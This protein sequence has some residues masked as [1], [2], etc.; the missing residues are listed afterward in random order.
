MRMWCKFIFLFCGSTYL[1]CM[2]HAAILG[3]EPTAPAPGSVR[4]IFVDRMYYPVDKKSDHKKGAAAIL[5][6]YNFGY[7]NLAHIIRHIGIHVL[8][9]CLLKWGSSSVWFGGCFF[10][11]IDLKLPRHMPP[12]TRTQTAASYWASSSTLLF[13]AKNSSS[14]FDLTLNNRAMM[15]PPLSC[16]T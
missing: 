8:H 2:G 12:P 1:I 7:R 3:N 15:I 9:L 11:H 10:G 13:K 5:W 4:K 6:N 16:Y 14:F